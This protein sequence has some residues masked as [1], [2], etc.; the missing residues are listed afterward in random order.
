MYS[1]F[2]L[3]DAPSHKNYAS[4]REGAEVT[5][6]REKTIN[7][8]GMDGEPVEK[9]DAYEA[10]LVRSYHEEFNISPEV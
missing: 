7:A 4:G 5:G 9:E 3:N 6:R 2:L 1:P 8:P 10:Q